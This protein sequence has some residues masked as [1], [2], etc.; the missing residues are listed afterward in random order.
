MARWTGSPSFVSGIGGRSVYPH[1]PPG[2]RVAALPPAPWPTSTASASC[3]AT[4]RPR[5]SSSPAHRPLPHF[6][7]LS[8]PESMHHRIHFSVPFRILLTQ[9]EKYPKVYVFPHGMYPADQRLKH[10]LLKPF[11]GW[12][13]LVGFY[14][15]CMTRCPRKSP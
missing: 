12:F 1:A 7:S 2:G 11:S 9:D 5:M 8:H 10:L 15:A 13:C 14:R 6:R 4:S 3:I